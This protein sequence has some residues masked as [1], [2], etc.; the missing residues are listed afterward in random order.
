MHKVP[1]DRKGKY[2]LGKE[3]HILAHGE[4]VPVPIWTSPRLAISTEE[5]ENQERPDNYKPEQLEKITNYL[6]GKFAMG[7]RVPYCFGRIGQLANDKYWEQYG[8]GPHF[9][10][11]LTVADVLKEC[12]YFTHTTDDNDTAI[13]CCG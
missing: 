11:D 13:R 1:F 8:K 10:S 3:N 12:P 7:I 5:F 2:V 4:W 9:K 6:V